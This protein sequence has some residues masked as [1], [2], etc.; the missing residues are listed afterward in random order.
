MYKRRLTYDAVQDKDTNNVISE[1]RS[2]KRWFLG[3]KFFDSE[4]RVKSEYVT[5]KGK[6]LGF[7]KNDSK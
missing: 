2:D 4:A 3:I 7:K 1:T 5:V 6:N